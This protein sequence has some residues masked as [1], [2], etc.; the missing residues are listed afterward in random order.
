MTDVRMPRLMQT[1]CVLVVLLAGCT[2]VTVRPRA[3]GL[4]D[5]WRASV[6]E[7]GGL[8]P[9]TLQT[10]RRYDLEPLYHQSA[11]EAQ[12]RLHQIAAEQPEPDALFALS[13]ICY[14]LGRAAEKER[15]H[16]ACGYYYLCAGYAFHYLFDNNLAVDP[17]PFDPRYR[18][19]CDLYNAGLA[20]CIRAAQR[21][22]RLDPRQALQVPAADGRKFTL[23][24]EHH[25][26][27][28]RAD[29]FGPLL[30]AE[31]FEVVGLANLYRGYGLGVPLIGTRD[32]A[33]PAPLHGFYPRAVG[34][35]VTAFFRFEG[36]IT[37]LGAAQAGK[38]ELYNPLTL[39]EVE[40][41]GRRVPLEFDL[42][43][44]QAYFLANTDLGDVT[45]AGFLRADRVQK[46]AGIYLFEPYQPGKIPVLMVHGLLSSPL[47]WMP[48]F[49]DLRA[50]P[51]LRERFQFWFYLYPTG[52]PYLETAA[53]LR[54]RLTQL[55][56]GLDPEHRDAALDQMVLVG[57][58][59]GGLVSRLLTTD[60]GDYFYNQISDRPLDTL[61][62]R[63]ETRA[64]LQR[65][66]FF[67]QQPYVRRVVFLGTPH[68]GSRLSPSF[69][70]R[71]AIRF[72]HLPDRLRDAARDVAT[73]NPGAW[74]LFSP[75]R[76][77]TSVDLLA[78]GAPALELLAALPRPNDVH[79]HSVIGILPGRAGQLGSILAGDADGSGSDGVVPY[80]S[81]HFEG[82]DS[83][84]IVT[85]DHSHV[86][87]HP[88]AV[89]EVRRILLEHLQHPPQKP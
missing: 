70:A 39:D 8:S 16:E 43:T 28:W 75:D 55:R 68:H 66:F 21:I 65:L 74:L 64:E 12:T 72:V 47:T 78:P 49:N 7:A 17:S 86:H 27:A 35:P 50:D 31:D 18:L 81:A 84:L 69:P 13:E 46:Q 24:V 9:R 4:F 63:P 76:L 6:A 73:E 51:V 61:K 83:E 53:D 77:P 26:F 82:A 41:R 62:I 22:G 44:P 29:E 42:T 36:T 15:P 30:F 14:T 10:L 38:L 71:L 79:F 54:E 2:G 25:G 33:A 45:Y 48:L 58:S 88:L 20:K 1:A 19:A 67:E 56:A 59:M 11:A 89:L 87:Q 52:T 5:A 23:S 37:D 3:P 85:A 80:R 60:S 32:R 34:F 40:V 57:H